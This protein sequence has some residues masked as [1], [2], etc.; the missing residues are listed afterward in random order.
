M[1]F[2]LM[3]SHRSHTVISQGL[4]L[5]HVQPGD[6]YK[7]SKDFGMTVMALINYSQTHYYESL[8]NRSL[9]CP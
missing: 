9:H 8:V 1:V 5:I 2:V 7:M 4:H 6:G 3:S